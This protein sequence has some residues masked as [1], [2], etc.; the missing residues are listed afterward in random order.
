VSEL[1]AAQA[2]L[3]GKTAADHLELLE[4]DEAD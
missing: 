1:L 2:Y 3:C 4:E